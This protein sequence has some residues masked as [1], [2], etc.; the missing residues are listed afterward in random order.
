[1]MKLWRRAELR[2][3]IK[4]ERIKAVRDFGFTEPQ[5]RFLLQV[6]IFS[7]VFIEPIYEAIG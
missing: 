5:G 4:P 1:M 7:G 3:S 6:L 2:D